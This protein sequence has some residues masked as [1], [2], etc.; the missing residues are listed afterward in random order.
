MK[1]LKFKYTPEDFNNPALRTHLK[2]IEILALGLEIETDHEGR[3]ILDVTDF[4]E[5]HVKSIE[6]KTG[7]IMRDFIDLVYTEG[8]DPTNT[9]PKKR[10][11]PAATARAA[12]VAKRGPAAA[13]AAASRGTGADHIAAAAEAGTLKKYT[14]AQL[15]DVS[16]QIFLDERLDHSM[17]II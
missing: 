6:K 8:Y 7:Q 1:K 11:Y 9:G 2:N 15:K 17:Q 3:R 12:P 10:A 13:A 14:V 5:P 4:T 16:A